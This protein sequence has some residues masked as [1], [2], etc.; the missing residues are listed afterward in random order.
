M[1]K[2]CHIQP[3]KDPLRWRMI[4]AGG[5]EI[6]QICE[7]HR[8]NWYDVKTDHKTTLEHIQKKGKPSE[9]DTSTQKD[10]SQS[11]R[12]PSERTFPSPELEAGGG[13]PDRM[14]AGQSGNHPTAS[15]GLVPTPANIP[16]RE[17]QHGLFS[18]HQPQ[19]G[20]RQF[21]ALNLSS[22]E[23]LALRQPVG[24]QKVEIRP[25]GIVYTSWSAV[26]DR[27]DDALGVGEWALVPEGQPQIEAGYCCWQ[28]H[29]YVHGQWACTSIGEHPD[30]KFSKMS[31]A[32]RAESAK[33]DALVKC[34]KA[35]G[36]FRELWDPG[37]REEWME[38][39]AVRVWALQT[40]RSTI[41]AWLWRRKDRLPFFK[42]RP[43]KDDMQTEY[44]KPRSYDDDARDHLDSIG[45]EN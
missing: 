25:D 3:C 38:K 9:M 33:S 8:Y 12:K 16:S 36:I 35:L 7:H 4:G 28:F 6:G 34:S 29:L 10:G 32:N 22:E 5:Y 42:E 11:R 30:N 40:E 20:N 31:L 41:G 45:D 19:E 15:T 37:W 13:D 44:H 1:P 39:N 17:G 24:S 27:L 14:E 2:R 26:A 23:Q 21:G 18:A 43:S